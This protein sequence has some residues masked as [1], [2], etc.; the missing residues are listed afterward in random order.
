MTIIKLGDYACT[1]RYC[2]GLGCMFSVGMRHILKQI[3]QIHISTGAEGQS[4]W[5]QS[6]GDHSCHN[7][8]AIMGPR[9]G[10]TEVFHDMC[11]TV[12]LQS[13]SDQYRPFL[14]ACV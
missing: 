4:D 14:Q 11:M 9:L 8:I 1:T 12:K 3:C 2:C 13:C 6:S 10:G 5:I 7:G